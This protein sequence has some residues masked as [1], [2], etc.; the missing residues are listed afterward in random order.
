M[1]ITNI[2]IAEQYTLFLFDVKK[3]H[4]RIIPMHQWYVTRLPTDGDILFSIIAMGVTEEDKNS[5]CPHK[6][7]LCFCCMVAEKVF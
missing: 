2:I 4:F 1:L 7:V 3:T 5:I 6:P